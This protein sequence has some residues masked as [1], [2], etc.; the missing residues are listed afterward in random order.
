MCIKTAGHHLFWEQGMLG[1]KGVRTQGWR[2]QA[3]DRGVLVPRPP[4]HT[5]TGELLNSSYLAKF[6]RKMK[7]LSPP[8][9]QAA[10]TSTTDSW[11]SKPRSGV[12]GKKQRSVET[13]Q[14]SQMSHLPSP[15][16]EVLPSSPGSP[17]TPTHPVL[18]VGGTPPAPSFHHLGHELAA[19]AFHRHSE[20]LHLPPPPPTGRPHLRCIP[21]LPAPKELQM[22]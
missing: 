19:P 8:M 18:D 5:L 6:F 3:G 15:R 4:S 7:R 9:G 11:S 16:C 21:L 12:K 22:T 1:E 10:C 14:A 20:L 13:S 2:V 17:S